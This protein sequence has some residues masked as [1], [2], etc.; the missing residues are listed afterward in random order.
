MSRKGDELCRGQLTERG[1]SEQ[2]RFTQ[3]W[4]G[5]PSVMYIK[6]PKSRCGAKYNFRT[7]GNG[8]WWS[9]QL[10]SSMEGSICIGAHSHGGIT[11]V[12]AH[13]VER[14]RFVE[15]ITLVEG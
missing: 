4:A 7:R 15:G 11:T 3:L 1:A 6:E 2:D 14:T 9:S 13:T 8:A 5:T 12:G 10:R